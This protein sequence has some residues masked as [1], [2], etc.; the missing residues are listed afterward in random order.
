MRL[1][2][3]PKVAVVE[4]DTA[5]A[6]ADRV[7]ADVDK[8]ETEVDK[9]DT[10]VVE[11]D[12]GAADED[13]RQTEASNHRHSTYITL[14]VKISPNSSPFREKFRHALMGFL[15]KPNGIF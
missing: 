14:V 12:E 11:M 2:L 5:V 8:A 6:E 13:Q 15:D 9:V 10:V 1:A 7:V 4:G 3:A